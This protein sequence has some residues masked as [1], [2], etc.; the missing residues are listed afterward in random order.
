M[1]R[2]ATT[3]IGFAA[4][5]GLLIAASQSWAANK[6][7]YDLYQPADLPP[8][9]AETRQQLLSVSQ[10]GALSGLRPI[11]AESD[12]F[13]FSYSVEPD[14]VAYWQRIRDRHEGRPV[15]RALAQVLALPAAQTPDGGFIWPYL[16]V[17]P[18]QPFEALSPAEAADVSLLMTREAWNARAAEIGYA[19][20]RLTIDADGNWTAFIAG[21]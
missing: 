20:Y 8:P 1:R 3:T 11:F 9:V 10:S 2:L 12:Y 19:G 4:V 13:Q 18:A 14:P 15:L 17:L 21:D 5:L 16:A 6:P 7:P